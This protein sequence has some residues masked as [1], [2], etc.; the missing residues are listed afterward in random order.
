M[1]MLQRAIHDPLFWRRPALIGLAVFVALLIFTG[2][3]LADGARYVEVERGPGEKFLVAVYPDDCYGDHTGGFAAT[4]DTSRPDIPAVYLCHM[5]EDEQH[6]LDHW[7]GMKHT[8]WQYAGRIA[9]ATITVAGYKTRYQEGDRI[10]M[11]RDT[12]YEW[13]ER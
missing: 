2:C 3:A 12:R 13:I 6:E 5:P 1:T 11:T 8:R 4:A 9:C 7:R 10:C